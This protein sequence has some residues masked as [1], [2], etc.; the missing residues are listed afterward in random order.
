LASCLC[1]QAQKDA[2]ELAAAGLKQKAK[3]FAGDYIQRHILKATC[4]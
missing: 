1:K 3:K 2:K 4:I